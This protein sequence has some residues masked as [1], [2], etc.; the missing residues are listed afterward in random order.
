M[1]VRP[2]RFCKRQDV[3]KDHMHDMQ[4]EQGRVQWSPMSLG[5]VLRDPS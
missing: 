3:L 1:L 5:T 4:E 2:R